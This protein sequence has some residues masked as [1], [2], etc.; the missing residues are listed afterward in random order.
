MADLLSGLSYE[1][2]ARPD[3]TR[4]GTDE[5]PRFA[6]EELREANRAA[7]VAALLLFDAPGA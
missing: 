4:S 5:G 2:W 7:E 3:S 1:I 6:G